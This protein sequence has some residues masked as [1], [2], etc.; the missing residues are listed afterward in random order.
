MKGSQLRVKKNGRVRTEKING[1]SSTKT[2]LPDPIQ[3]SG[4]FPPKVARGLA[5]L[6][7]Y[8]LF[9]AMGAK[10]IPLK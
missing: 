4:M 9:R 7:L 3:A 8:T 10:L 1:V 5:K 6:I 2:K